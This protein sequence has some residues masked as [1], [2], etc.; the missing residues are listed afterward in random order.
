MDKALSLDL[1]DHLVCDFMLNDFKSV[2]T[3]TPFETVE[4]LILEENQRFIPVVDNEQHVKGII[5]R[6][7]F[8]RALLDEKTSSTTFHDLDTQ[9]RLYGWQNVRHLMEET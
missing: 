6:T 3:N 8:L 7:D 5:S 9:P 2:D 1:G 4:S